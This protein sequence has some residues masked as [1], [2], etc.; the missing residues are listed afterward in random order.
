MSLEDAFGPLSPDE[1]AAQVRQNATKSVQSSLW[2]H[3]KTAS[4]PRS[5]AVSWVL[6]RLADPSGP[7]FGPA[8]S[9]VSRRP[10]R[11]IDVLLGCARACDSSRKADDAWR[12]VSG[13]IVRELSAIAALAPN[14]AP[15]LAT[16]PV[17]RAVG[18]DDEL[19]DEE[20]NARM[21]RFKE[22]IA[23]GMSKEAA[24]M[25]AVEESNKRKK[26]AS[27]ED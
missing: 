10:R 13:A 26:A 24:A 20:F 3:L 5:G 25:V 21:V 19:S 8:H 22:L 12:E 17:P 1:I 6:V 14:G 16:A 18:A 27:H 4:V 11:E 15:T 7:K 23:G 9:A 2:R